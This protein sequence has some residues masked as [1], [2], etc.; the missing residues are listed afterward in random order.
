MWNSWEGAMQVYTLAFEV[1]VM[2]VTPLPGGYW[3]TLFLLYEISDDGN[4]EHEC[5]KTLLVNT[6][7]SELEQA[8]APG[9]DDDVGDDESVGDNMEYKFSIDNDDVCLMAITGFTSADH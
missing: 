9:S 1:N 3:D 4:D 5:K 7:D 6:Y 8:L 2:T